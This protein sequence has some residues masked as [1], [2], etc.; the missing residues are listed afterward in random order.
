MSEQMTPSDALLK[1]MALRYDHGF[2]LLTDDRRREGILSIMRQLWE[3]VAGVGFYRGDDTIS[4]LKADLTRAH[5]ALAERDHLREEV[6]AWRERFYQME[7]RR[8]DDCIDRK[9][10]HQ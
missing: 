7:Y 8:A 2:G 9:W 6:A 4:A 3:E 1:S 10:D 5:E